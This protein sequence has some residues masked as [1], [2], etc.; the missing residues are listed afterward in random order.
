MPTHA[1]IMKSY[2]YLLF[3]FLFTYSWIWGQ[4]GTP[5]ANP[6][7]ALEIFSSDK[8]IL[9]TR[10]HLTATTSF[11]PIS[12]TPSNDDE[13]LLVYNT[14]AARSSG[15]QGTGF[16]YWS[17]GASGRWTPIHQSITTT[18]TDSQTLTA[19]LNGT[20]LELLPENTTN[21]VTVDLS[22][23]ALVKVTE[24]GS[25][26]FRL[27]SANENNHGPIGQHAID[28]SFQ[29]TVNQTRGAT[30]GN[31]MAWGQNT[32]ASDNYATA[33]GEDTTASGYNAT[34]W[35]Q[36]TTA[37]GY[38]TT[39]WGVGTE[40]NDNY[41]TAWGR[42]SRAQS[43][44]ATAWGWRTLASGYGSTA[45]GDRTT[46]AGSEATSFGE[47]TV[48]EAFCQTSFGRYNTQQTPI[49]DSLWNATDRLWV[50]GNGTTR[51]QSGQTVITRSDALVMLKNGDTTVSGVWT[52]DFND[53]SD[54]RYKEDISTLV[55]ALDIVM[56]LR[57]VRYHW[58]ENMKKGNG[59]DIGVIAQE[60]EAHVPE[61]V[62]TDEKGYKSVHY[63]KLSA[64]LIE[65][66]K[67]QQKQLETV[68]Q[69]QKEQEKRLQAIEVQ[70]GVGNRN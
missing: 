26:G 55:D 43:R 50:I 25:W 30:A 8:G 35:G 49:S 45:W 22:D 56:Q 23:F 33:W 9:I 2:L 54:A 60:I 44:F 16:Y 39:T 57:G 4:Q 28:L 52:G 64:L 21:S 17:G 32:V 27:N 51:Q 41:A 14:N 38:F 70:L 12:G 65:A 37:S 29:T 18:N 53:T 7:A 31:A 59:W 5:T 68:T 1:T 6:S 62:H 67:T 69:K 15:L 63:G 13:G 42:E 66:L 10:V 19:S 3:S 24:N 20:S 61:I 46:A 58:R 36:D 47:G 11:A 34:A 40:A 48:A